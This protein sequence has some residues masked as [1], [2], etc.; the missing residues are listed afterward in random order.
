LPSTSPDP[1][2]DQQL[3]QTA[4]NYAGAGADADQPPAVRF[5]RG[6]ANLVR[7]RLRRGTEDV[8][9]PA[10]FL[11]CPADPQTVDR[12]VLKPV[13][14]LD[15]GLTPVVGKLWLVGPP[16]VSGRCMPLETLEDNALFELVISSL[17][18]GDVPAVIYDPRADPNQI[19]YYPTG[20]QN[21][22][23]CEIMDIPT[24][25]VDIQRILG[26]I[27]RIC[28]M[29]LV[30]PDAQGQ[31]AKL[32]EKP[33]RHWVAEKAELTIQNYLVTAFFAAFPTCVVRFEQ[34]QVTGRLDIEIEEP[35]YDH[36]GHVIKQAL[37]ELKVLR[38]FGSTGVPYTN[39]QVQEW[40]DKG[41]DQAY[42]YREERR[43]LQ[44]AL[45][46][47]DMRK[48]HEDVSGFDEVAEKANR[49]AVTVRRWR[50]FASAE[51]YRSFLSAQL[52][53]CNENLL[54]LTVI[55][56]MG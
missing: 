19:R 34:P 5:L 33:R 35:D 54:H 55:R 42:A 47:F 41:V 4:G 15:N 7:K 46:C 9:A 50:L 44:S 27:D 26:V 10:V 43:A 3:L 29:Q 21:A 28:K 51:A 39:A 32:W 24:E 49:L 38:S 14:M 1:W 17:K 56:L 45:C 12:E 52:N 53:L 37:L 8:V 31:E 18:Q 2:S 30:T 23:A 6:V 36:R 25:F 22:D 40:I 16:V 20:L 48:S 13:E 11:L